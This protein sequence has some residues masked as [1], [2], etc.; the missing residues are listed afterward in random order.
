MQNICLLFSGRRG[1]DDEGTRASVLRIPEVSRKLK[2]AQAIID[3]FLTTEKKVDL[4]S[5]VQANNKTFNENPSLK[6]LA[7][8]TV[9]IGLFERF[10]K[11]RNRPQFLVGPTNG[12]AAMK[13][14]AG[15]QDFKDFVETSDFCN[16][17]TLLARFTQQETQLAGFKMED[18]GVLVWNPDGFYQSLEVDAKNAVNIIEDLNASYLLS[19]VV[20]LGPTYGFRDEEFNGAELLSLAT[21]SS[22]EMDPIL[23]SFWKSAI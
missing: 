13:V 18:Y 17:N 7:A 19:Q 16:E 4:F 1:L 6:A 2:E 10:V 11:Y 23:N 21:M 12:N 15:L 20:H 5:F 22:I 14:C 8:A 3:D 9:Q